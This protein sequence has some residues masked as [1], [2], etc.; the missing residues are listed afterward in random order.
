MCE[1]V[2]DH[3]VPYDTSMHRMYIA[4]SEVCVDIQLHTMHR[5]NH[6]ATNKYIVLYVTSTLTNTEKI[7]VEIVEE[8]NNYNK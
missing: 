5:I 1:I 3:I 2:I 7:V 4:L 6:L 8:G